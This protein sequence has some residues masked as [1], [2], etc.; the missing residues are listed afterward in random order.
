MN[1]L[2]AFI[3]NTEDIC[4]GF[5]EEFHIQTG[6]AT[7][8]HV[9]VAD[10]I[11]VKCVKPDGGPG[12]IWAMQCVRTAHHHAVCTEFTAHFDRSRI[13]AWPTG[14]LPGT[15]RRHWNNRRYGA[16]KLRPT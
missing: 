2:Y 6:V 10:I 3:S 4:L 7:Q 14:R 15:L 5:Q 16:S 8:A 9:L 1:L 12:Y 13:T 11:N